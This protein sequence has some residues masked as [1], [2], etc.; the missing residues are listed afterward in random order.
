MIGQN[1]SLAGGEEKIDLK[2]KTSELAYCFCLH[3]NIVEE[4]NY[5]SIRF[6]DASI[7]FSKKSSYFSETYTFFDK[8]VCLKLPIPG[9]RLAI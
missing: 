4:A 3:D 2:K 1:A 8:N 5:T 9:K 7:Y 6:S